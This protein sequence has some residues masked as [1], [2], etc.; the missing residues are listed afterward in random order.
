[1][2]LRKLCLPIAAFAAVVLAATHAEAL[3]FKLSETKEQLKLD[4]EVSATDHGTGRVT[5]V[6]TLA[7]EGRLGPLS[8][9][10]LV[11][12]SEAG[13]GHVDLSVSL[14]TEKRD[15]GTTVA[16]VHL[17]KELAERAEFQLR[18][19]HLDGKQTPRTWYYHSIPFADYVRD[20]KQK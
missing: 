8:G 17:K 15:D 7:E 13:T 18:T 3:G 9:V 16:R 11:V 1:M 10:Q 19:W 12:P 14:N 20:D 6:L 4:Y 5:L 2:P